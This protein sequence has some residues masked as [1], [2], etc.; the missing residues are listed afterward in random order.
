MGLDVSAWARLVRIEGE[1][2]DEMIGEG[3]VV[4][5]HASSEFPGRTIG[6]KDGWYRGETL[7]FG[8]FWSFRA[9]SY[10]G[11]NTWRDQLAKLAGYAAHPNAQELYGTTH[12]HAATAWEA[13]GG[14]F[15]E[16]LHFSDCSGVIGPQVS[17]KLARDFAA[18]DERA[19]AAADAEPGNGWFYRA[20]CDWRRAFDWAAQDG[21]VEFH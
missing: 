2:D 9:G 12:A 10:S 5:V 17:A 1:P 7:Q 11:Y 4:R 6:L 19:K 16:L 3:E 15:W 8:D 14:P 20:Y 13:T 21:C 18:L